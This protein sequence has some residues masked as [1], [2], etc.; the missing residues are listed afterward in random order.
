LIDNIFETTKLIDTKFER[1]S[2]VTIQTSQVVQRCHT[3]I[4]DGEQSPF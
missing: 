4:Q 2:P 3:V 1:R